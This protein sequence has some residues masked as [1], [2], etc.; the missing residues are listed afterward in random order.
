M[1]T[2]Q[3]LLAVGENEQ[4]RMDFIRRVINEHKGSAAYRFAVDAQRYYD[5]ENPTISRY[6][7]IFFVF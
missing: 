6:E 3:D 2:Y 4:D 7:K 1:L 5:G